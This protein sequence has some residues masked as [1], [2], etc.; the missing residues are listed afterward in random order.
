MLSK[1]VHWFVKRYRIM[2]TTL[3]FIH[4][5]W[6]K[7]WKN[8]ICLYIGK[9]CS[10]KAKRFCGYLLSRNISWKQL[11]KLSRNPKENADMT[12]LSVHIISA[13]VTIS[14]IRNDDISESALV[15]PYF[16]F[17][18]VIRTCLLKKSLE[19]FLTLTSSIFFWYFLWLYNA[20]FP[21]FHKLDSFHTIYT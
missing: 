2:V 19:P 12:V 15:F 17:K 8:V 20:A 11:D 9:L 1:F 4:Q 10:A 6:K 3:D 14:L 18:V 13:F 16:F 5:N 7:I 21:M